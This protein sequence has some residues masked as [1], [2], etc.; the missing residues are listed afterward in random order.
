MK[1]TI[2]SFD[3]DGPI[4][5]KFAMGIPNGS[6]QATFAPNR[7]PHI[8][9]T[10]APK[11]TK[12]FA[13]ICHDADAPTVG[14]DVNQPGRTVPYDLPRA[15]FYHWVLVDIP[16][17]INE[18]PAGI[19]S[20]GVTPKGK[21]VGKTPYGVRGIN[22][23]T[24]WF[25]GD[26]N[27]EGNYG[28]Y[29]GPFPPWNDERVHRYYFTLYALDVASLNLSGAFT[30][31]EALAAMQGHVLAQDGWMGTYAIYANARP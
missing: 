14:D 1:L 31:D 9:W 8:R 27:M 15:D 23:Y 26:P 12:S 19:D 5:T 6:G 22:S 25:A 3:N 10:D 24:S 18:L 7:S 29:D 21:E 30:G 4:P 2:L 16:A 28:G 17:D 13:L 11:E 20:D